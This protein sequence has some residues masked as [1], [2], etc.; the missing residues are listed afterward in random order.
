MKIEN[1]GLKFSKAL[2]PL[3]CVTK[4]IIHHPAHPTWG[5][6]EI[7]DYHKKS[8]GWNGIGYSYFIPKNGGVQL[9]RGRNVGAHCKGMGMNN[10]SLGVCFQGAFDKQ[11]P[12]EEQYRDGAKLIAQLLRQ[13]G[14]QINDVA[15]HRDFDATACPGKNFDMNKLKQYILE[16]MNP[17]VKGVVQA[18]SEQVKVSTAT[19]NAIDNLAG[20]GI[21]QKDYK[22][23]K[24]HEI[25]LISMLNGL[26]NAIKN[27][28]LK[29]K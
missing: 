1:V 3:K 21:I 6:K 7:H 26:V 29:V 10:Q 9:G 5:M 8:N 25:T 17:N 15:P 28:K 11:I 4:I 13:E 14:L 20:Y 27:G 24:D 23:T 12:T 16:E 19:Q 18:V 2:I 22:V